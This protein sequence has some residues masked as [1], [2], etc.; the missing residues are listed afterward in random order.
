M[1]R[2]E[3]IY[4][5][6]WNYANNHGELAGNHFTCGAQWADENPFW[7]IM[8]KDALP[9]KC[10]LVYCAILDANFMGEYVYFDLLTYCPEGSEREQT[11]KYGNEYTEVLTEDE[12]LQDGGLFEESSILAWIP[13]PDFDRKELGL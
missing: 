6:A 11:D 9:D 8:G 12:W 4:N 2:E 5:E 3:Q 13:I 10:T 7:R 1:T